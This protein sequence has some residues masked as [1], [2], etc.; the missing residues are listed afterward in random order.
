MQP[1]H[2]LVDNLWTDT[3]QYAISIIRE[4]F[5][6]SRLSQELVIHYSLW[7]RRKANLDLLPIL[8]LE[9][10]SLNYNIIISL[11]VAWQIL[12]CSARIFDD[13]EDD[14][15]GC[16]PT[17]INIGTSFLLLAQQV[18]FKLEA[19]GISKD[20]TRL[21]ITKYNQIVFE[22]CSGQ[23]DDLLGQSQKLEITPEIWLDIAYRK[24]GA[25]F[26]WAT[27]VGPFLANVD[28]EI[29]QN[30]GEFARFLG[31]LIQVTDDLNDTWKTSNSGLI[32][33]DLV[34][35]AYVYGKFVA[36]PKVCQQIEEWS[37]FKNNPIQSKKEIQNLLLNLGAQK[38]LFA[39][40][41]IQK[42][43]ALESIQKNLPSTNLQNLMEL[44]NE[45]FPDFPC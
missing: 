32:K 15:T 9:P 44:I 23:H 5:T 13:I 38:Y 2:L 18:I 35:L 27:W 8:V 41:L 4:F 20:Q 42:Q 24:S 19:Y 16:K 3:E 40:A 25:L 14:D 36:T 11:V 30:Y 21:I 43:K 6:D 7:N 37:G 10:N 29:I 22:A 39:A 28:T 34:S 1:N 31:A 12:Q 17:D 26:S 45:I 33:S